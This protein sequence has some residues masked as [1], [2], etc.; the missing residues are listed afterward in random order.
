[1]CWVDKDDKGVW[2]GAETASVGK[3]ASVGQDASVG[4]DASVGQDT[5]VGQGASACVVCIKH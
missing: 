1:M 2:L 3:D 4:K 5:S